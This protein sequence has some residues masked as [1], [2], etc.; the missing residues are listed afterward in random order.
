MLARCSDWTR[1]GYNESVRC[2]AFVVREDVCALSSTGLVLVLRL[3]NLFEVF[4]CDSVCTVSEP[5]GRKLIL[6]AM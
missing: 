2:M 1:T 6:S 4:L 5:K 3:L